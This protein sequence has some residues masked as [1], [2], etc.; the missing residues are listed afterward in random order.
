[1]SP[2][3][4]STQSGSTT[5]TSTKSRM[6]KSSRRWAETKGSPPHPRLFGEP[7]HSVD[8]VLDAFRAHG[9]RPVA[10]AL[11]HLGENDPHV[12]LGGPLEPWVEGDVDI[13]ALHRPRLQPRTVRPLEFLAD[14]ADP[15]VDAQ[16]VLRHARALGP[17]AP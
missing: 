8:G 14:L 4:T 17:L 7:P 3:D 9:P 5:A 16:G 1:C 2:H 10:E 6:P 15:A 13:V 11:V 12:C